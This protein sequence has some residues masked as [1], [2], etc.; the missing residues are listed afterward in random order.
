MKYKI[1]MD[2]KG[3]VI[4]DKKLGNSLTQKKAE[5]FNY[6]NEVLDNKLVKPSI[7]I[8]YVNQYQRGE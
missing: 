8:E 2:N 4:V 7:I 1:S 5:F 6:L 3:K